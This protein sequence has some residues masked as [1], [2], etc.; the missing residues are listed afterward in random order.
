MRRLLAAALPAVFAAGL[1]SCASAPPPPP[2]PRP[3]PAPEPEPAPVAV[4][5]SWLVGSKSANVRETASTKAPTVARLS[6]GARL[7]SFE[8][9]E[10]W[11][12]VKLADTRT[13]WIRK[14]LLRKDDGCLPDRREV[15]LTPPMLHMSQGSGGSGTPETKGKVVVEAE[16]DENGK[17][18]T[19]RVVQNETGSP[20]RAEIAKSEVQGVTF[21]PPVKKCRVTGFTY[22]YTRTF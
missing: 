7:T 4:E 21:Q 11:L 10:G 16:I 15:L 3:V 14:D 9:K 13:G 20:E 1:W 22:V 17:V 5:T 6:R 19:V 18:R 12:R 2:A 8:E